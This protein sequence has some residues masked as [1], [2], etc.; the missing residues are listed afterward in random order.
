MEGIIY[1]ATCK[2]TG[3]CYIGQT[4]F[5]LEVRMNTHKE[6]SKGRK[7]KFYDAIRQY[8]WNDFIW[9]TIDT[10]KA[11]E[12]ELTD[13][14]NT[15]EI[16]WISVFDSFQNGYN[17]DKGGGMTL[18]LRYVRH[19]EDTKKRIGDKNR[20]KTRPEEAKRANSVAS[21]EYWSDEN[22][23][24]HQSDKMTDKWKDDDFKKRHREAMEKAYENEEYHTKLSESGKIAWSNQELRDKQAQ[25]MRETR[26]GESHPNYGKRWM[27]NG[28]DNM[29]VFPPWDKDMLVFGWWYG[30][31]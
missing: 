29:L 10:V 20:G 11:E 23:R 27:T 18:E 3:L 26:Q 22:H 16:Y 19:R 25:R 7:G 14:L 13:T 6:N 12:P 21:K 5:P 4:V 24:Q 17:G 2:T 28:K 30:R 8:G 1:K 31:T 9:E 15:K